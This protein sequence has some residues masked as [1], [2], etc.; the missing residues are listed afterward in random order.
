MHTLEWLFLTALLFAVAA[1][2]SSIRARHRTLSIYV[3]NIALVAALLNAI[4]DGTRWQMYPAYL[5]A[6]G[7]LAWL[8]IA[9]L[10]SRARIARVPRSLRIGIGG[11]GAMFVMVSV[12]LGSLLPVFHL[13]LPT[14][15]Y[16]VGVTDL[17]FIDSSRVE[18]FSRSDGELR[19]IVAKAWYPTQSAE[20]DKAPYVSDARHFSRSF[21][22]AMGVPGFLLS[23]V[24]H[25][26]TASHISAPIPDT[27]SFPVLLF[28]HGY[29]MGYLEQ[30]TALLQ[31][32][33]SHGY[34]VVSIGHLYEM[35]GTSLPDGRMIGMSAQR[36]KEID[37]ASDLVDAW[38]NASD[39]AEK[40]GHMRE[41][42]EASTEL[43]RSAWIWTEDSRFVLDQLAEMHDAKESIA[44]SMDLD[45]IGAFGHSFGG[46]TAYLLAQVDD[47]VRAGANLDGASYGAP[48]ESVVE[49]PFLF[50]ESAS[51]ALLHADVFERASGPAY[52]ITMEGVEHLDFSDFS[53]WGP[54]FRLAGLSGKLDPE[55][56][57]K[58]TSEVVRT[59]FDRY[60]RDG[61][62]T[63]PVLA[64]DR[65]QLVLAASK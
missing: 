13:P 15:Q 50:L 9:S 37:Q 17:Y 39:A 53:L 62:E 40:L 44:G 7:L 8:A 18:V 36:M 48:P 45:R 41:I 58:L 4:V 5:V 6:A 23:H 16:A 49:R 1:V 46:A 61:E 52:R 55:S 11:L 64:D 14:G 12:A 35:V 27:E 28:S 59:F 20:G 65:P 2:A 24:K 42:I 63:L 21:G 57:H 3:V 43:A 32:L 34:I 31:E 22:K 54:L 19:E 38:M 25:V 26:H 10:R 60:L 47:R 33:A 56:T 51:N 30:S 29:G